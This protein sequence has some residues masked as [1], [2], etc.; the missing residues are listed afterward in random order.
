MI[1]NYFFVGLAIVSV[2]GAIF[3]SIYDRNSKKKNIA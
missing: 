2:L 1:A 3:I